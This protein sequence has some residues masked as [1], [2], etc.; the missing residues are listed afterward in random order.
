MADE[1]KKGGGGGRR[2]PSPAVKRA[3]DEAEEAKNDLKAARKSASDARKRD[4]EESASLVKKANEAARRAR[5]ETREARSGRVIG[6]L[7]FNLSAVG[8]T[9]AG[10]AIGDSKLG[11]TLNTPVKKRAPL[12]L[13]G[14]VVAVLGPE[15]GLSAR[16]SDGIGM[17]LMAPADVALGEL[18]YQKVKEAAAN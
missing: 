5:E 1:E 14:A 6:H 8:S 3:R 18:A 7:L 13:L 2:G 10:E 17:G 11:E 9:M 16:I 4:R 15:I 12:A